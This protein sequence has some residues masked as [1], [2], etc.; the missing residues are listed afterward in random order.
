MDQL[1]LQLRHATFREAVEFMHRH[2][3]DRMSVDDANYIEGYHRWLSDYTPL[4]KRRI[5]II[6]EKLGLTSAV[7][8]Y[9]GEE[10]GRPASDDPGVGLA[11]AHSRAMDLFASAD[12]V[13]APVRRPT[14]MEYIRNIWRRFW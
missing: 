10:P 5:K 1:S 14:L 8:L 11:V 4:Q 12:P 7:I 9:A 2:Y 3:M 6:L 13:V